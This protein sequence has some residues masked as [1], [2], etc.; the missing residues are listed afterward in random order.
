MSKVLANR[1]KGH[2]QLCI[3]RCQSAFLK[4]RHLHD[5]VASAL[6]IIHY[7]E[8]HHVGGMVFKIDFRKA[9]DSLDQDFL[10]QVLVAKGMPR[11]WIRW[12]CSLLSDTQ[13]CIILNGTELPWFQCFTRVRQ[14]DP[15]SPYLFILALDTLSSILARAKDLSLIRGLGGNA[16]DCQ[17]VHLLYADDALIFCEAS[18][19]MV[20][21]LKRILMLFGQVSC[22]QINLDKSVGTL[23]GRHD[24]ELEDRLTSIIG[25]GIQKLPWSYLGIPLCIAKPPR[26]A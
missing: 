21:R 16:L 12:I 9:F 24:D 18:P 4:G 26:V 20:L 3:D 25:C 7:C 22:L 19:L 23:I 6:E 1:L 8:Q 5:N 10:I 2:L 14:G 11:I 15:L 13:S 17:F